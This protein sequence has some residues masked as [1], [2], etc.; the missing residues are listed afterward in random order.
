MRSSTVSLAAML[1]ASIGVGCHSYPRSAGI[2]SYDLTEGYRFNDL[3]LDSDSVRNS[4]GLFVVLAFSGG[5]TRAAALSYGVLESLRSVRLPI[6]PTTGLPCRRTCPPGAD[7]IALVDEVDVI[8]SVSGGSFAAGYYALRGREIFTDTTA[9]KTAFLYYPAQRDLLGNL[10]FK[11]GNWKY[12][13]SRVELAAKQWGSLFGDATFADLR[14]GSRPYLILNSTDILTGGRFEFTQEQFDLFCGDL[15][16]FPLRR[17]VAASSAFPGLLTPMTLDSY[18]G[19]C[20]Y[21]DPL[22]FGQALGDAVANYELFR[23]A[24]Q[25]ES[26][27]D[28]SRRYLHV[29]DGGVA[30]NLGVRALLQSLEQE[31]VPNVEVPGA[32]QP[33][34][35]GWSLL[36][37]INRGAANRATG[38]L[39]F[40]DNPPIDDI[41]VIVV[42]ARTN[43]A[44]AWGESPTPPNPLAAINASAGIPIGRLS[45]ESMDLLR[46][47]GFNAGLNQDGRPGFYG[48]EVAFE[49]ISDLD[50]R[51]FFENLGTNFQLSRFEV[52]CLI[53]RGGRLLRESSSLTELEP[54]GFG[55]FVRD[56]LGGEITDG[57]APES[58]CTERGAKEAG[59]DPTH[60]IDVGLHYSFATETRRAVRLE[61]RVGLSLRIARPSGWG[62]LFSIGPRDFDVTGPLAGTTLEMGDFRLWA[63][64]AGLGYTVRKGRV[65]V[66][67]GVTVGY[68][69]GDFEIEDDLRQR[70]GQELGLFDFAIEAPGSLI[71]QAELHTWL[72]L[73]SAFALTGFA[74]YMYAEPHLD[75]VGDR[76]VFAGSLVASGL[77][78]GV[79]L[80]FRVY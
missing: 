18:A 69:F 1:A 76:T 4:N 62:A 23:R 55:E 31:Q 63:W 5:G 33:I 32:D 13:G 66:T 47:Y 45:W 59:G 7:T 42:N 57:E 3:A 20:G 52:D 58:T 16:A 10:V 34:E 79:G 24:R 54:R 2:E 6:D 64:T 46:Q 25:M 70:V 72:N 11:P 49:N 68:A 77:R 39:V 80:G 48:F 36:T 73:T 27:R 60:V 61:D 12:L 71:A 35:G 38:G 40:P 28:T 29:M 22:W 14:R 37:M 19:R 74:Q 67:P 78:L 44:K 26:Y 15:S 21:T 41:V 75:I 53:D 30:D 56:V 9:F 43:T 17:A 8:S 65:D 50:E 51:S